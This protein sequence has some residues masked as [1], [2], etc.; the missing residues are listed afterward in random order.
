MKI[1]FTAD[2]HVGKPFK[3]KYRNGVS[4]RS[5]DFVE[6]LRKVSNYSIN[7]DVDL[8][9]VGGDLYDKPTINATIKKI[10]RKNVFK[11]LID[12]K[13]ATLVI[14]G[15]HDSPAQFQ[16]GADIEDL[17]ISKFINSRRGLCIK[18]YDIKGE[19]LGFILLPYLQGRAVLDYY[20]K[21]QNPGTR[22]ESISNEQAMDYL[23]DFVKE[24][25]RVIDGVDRKFIVGHY[26][27]VGTLVKKN[28]PANF[29]LKEMQ[30][31]RA[32]LHEN[33][34]DLAVFGHVHSH[35]VI[36]DKI[37]IP[38]STERVDFGE[39]DDE[40]CF[41]EYDTGT[42]KW[43]SIPLECRPMVQIEVDVSSDGGNPKDAVVSAIKD[44]VIDNAMVKVVI[45]AT[46]RV[47]IA[48]EHG[49]SD[50]EKALEGCFHPVISW[51]MLGSDGEK[52]TDAAFLNLDPEM[53]LE[54]FVTMKF[55]D[56]RRGVVLEKAMSI[57]RSCSGD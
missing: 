9:V 11:P 32:M 10:L 28:L 25:I 36:G 48:I 51:K 37:I 24:K 14:G 35:Q 47:R 6:Q 1:V 34:I 5:I 55:D 41:V 20:I 21:K 27:V 40:K 16:R 30:V 54:A 19:K 45:T 23:H 3:F 43:K 39:R 15:N 26:H 17:E 44:S 2:A 42:G 29:M 12:N 38:G 50:I 18:T 4:E 13:V 31:N 22:A 56:Q 57:L 52:M 7:N 33:E 46:Q 8:L 53:L 49:M